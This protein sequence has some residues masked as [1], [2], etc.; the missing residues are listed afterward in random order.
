MGPKNSYNNI[1]N[2]TSFNDYEFCF[3]FD[4]KDLKKYPTNGEIDNS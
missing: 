4:A 1:K 3:S 2:A